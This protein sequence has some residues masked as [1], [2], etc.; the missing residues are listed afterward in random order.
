MRLR[1]ALA[2][3]LFA[4]PALAAEYD[5]PW[6]QA[7]PMER[8][9]DLRLCRQ[10]AGLVDTRRCRNAETAETRAYARRLRSGG[11]N[12]RE[13]WQ[14]DPSRWTTLRAN[15]APGAPYSPTTRYCHLYRGA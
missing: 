11:I 8:T 12:T 13:W 10:D 7:R 6:Y 1:L 4:A 5:V 14:A 2:A 9:R 3:M 15:C